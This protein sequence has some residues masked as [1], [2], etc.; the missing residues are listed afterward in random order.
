MVNDILHTLGN[1]AFPAQGRH[2][3][4]HCGFAPN[5]SSNKHQN[6]KDFN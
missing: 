1:D 6:V 4:K 2:H 3:L 5:Y